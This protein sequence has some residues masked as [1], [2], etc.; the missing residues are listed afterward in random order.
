MHTI[1]DVLTTVGRDNRVTHPFRP[2]HALLEL[3]NDW[4][5]SVTVGPT[6][7]STLGQCFAA[8]LEQPIETVGVQGRSG[9]PEP[10][11]AMALCRCR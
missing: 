9:S 4:Q 11:A 6:S 8:G 7:V 3:P 2:S 5:L 10:G 1:W